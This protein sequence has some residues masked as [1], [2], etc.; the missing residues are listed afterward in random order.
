M[1]NSK[2]NPE[3]KEY[4]WKYHNIRLQIILQTHSQNSSMIL[5]QKQTLGLIEQNRKFRN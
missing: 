4:H 1:L 3:K 5:A 2:S